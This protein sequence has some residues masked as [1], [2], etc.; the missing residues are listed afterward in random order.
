MN[1]QENLKNMGFIKSLEKG[2]FF[3]FIFLE[4]QEINQ[5]FMTNQWLQFNISKPH[6]ENTELNW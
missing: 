6:D 1:A 5:G 4:I 2:Y 3:I